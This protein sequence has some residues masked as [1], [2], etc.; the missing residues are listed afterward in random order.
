MT[1]QLFNLIG[2]SCPGC[3]GTGPFLLDPADEFTVLD[4]G[5]LELPPGAW[6]LDIECDCPACG[7]GGRL[8]DFCGWVE[9]TGDERTAILEGFLRSFET[10]L[11]ADRAAREDR[12]ESMIAAYDRFLPVGALID[13]L[14]DAMLWADR[15][16][17]SFEEQLWK[18]ARRIYPA[19]TRGR[20]AAG[21]APASGHPEEEGGV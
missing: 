16:G 20:P 2:K 12:F 1:K 8:E 13:L 3:K 14:E 15:E 10:F 6:G 19:S 11:A 9:V 17:I 7:F 21:A 4:D 5:S 18:A